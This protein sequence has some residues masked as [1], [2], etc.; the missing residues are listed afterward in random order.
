MANHGIKRHRESKLKSA[1][2]F[3]P[4]AESNGNKFNAAKILGVSRS[5][6]YRFFA[7]QGINSTDS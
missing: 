6:L 4:L 7:K 1:E 2:V 3:K 5:T